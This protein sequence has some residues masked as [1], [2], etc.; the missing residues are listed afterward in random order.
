MLSAANSD[1]KEAIRADISQRGILR[2]ETQR[3]INRAGG[4]NAWLFDLRPLC[5]DAAFLESF[6]NLFWQTYAGRHPFQVGGMEV[7]AIPLVTAIVMKSKMY[8]TPV[9]GFVARRERKTYGVGNII[10]G[11]ILPDTPI[12]IV[13]DIFNSGSS[14]EKVRVNLKALSHSIDSAFVIIDF[15]SLNGKK[16]KSLNRVEVK[17]IFNLT[18]FDLSLQKTSRTQVPD[19]FEDKWSFISPDPNFFHRIPKSFP[20]VS[21]D[22]IFFGS[23]CGIFWCL[24]ACDGKVIWKFKVI[25]RGHKNIWSTA[26]EHHGKVY[27]GAYDG[28]LYCLDAN[29]GLEIWRFSGADWI[30]S[31][32]AIAP[33]IGLLFIGLQYSVNEKHGGI[34]AFD[35][36]TGEMV[37]HHQ[38]KRYTQA[39]PAYY[40]RREI[41]TCGSND[42]ELMLFDARSGRLLWRFASA[43]INGLKGSFR[44]AATF[45]TERSQIVAGCANGYIYVVDIDSG[46]EVFSV[47]T[48]GTIYTIPLVV[49]D[50]AY[51]G[52]TDKHLYILDLKGKQ[53][54]SKLPIGGKIFSPAT[55][56]N[57]FIYFSGT[58]GIVYEMDPVLDVITGIHQL[59][60]AITNRIAYSPQT[61]LFY[62]LTYV[63]QLFAMAHI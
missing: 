13:D 56:I 45:D 17:S 23:D 46:K 48:D 14:L 10:E 11:N 5:L 47:K 44:H 51:I 58:D 38:T 24:N 27:F 26:C 7:A 60:D 18:E 59:P 9:N 49:G 29:S 42:N 35:L 40:P 12:I 4:E 28:N 8:G 21:G 16:W 30:G 50:K 33:D 55:Y 25:T 6:A 34:A 53:L 41:M 54:K 39:S 2:S 57:N 62:A 15:L 31:S 3:L 1:L 61:N 32:P 20:L 43:D 19:V 52:S 22:K 37:W 36:S 63:N